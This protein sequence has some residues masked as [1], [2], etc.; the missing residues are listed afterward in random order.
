[1]SE[2]LSEPESK[3]GSKR[4]LSRIPVKAT[5]LYTQSQEDADQDMQTSHFKHAR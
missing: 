3:P 4:D 2:G 1:M 5:K